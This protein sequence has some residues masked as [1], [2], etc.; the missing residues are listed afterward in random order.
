MSGDGDSL[1]QPGASP[2]ASSDGGRDAHIGSHASSCDGG[3]RG[4][5]GACSG[6]FRVGGATPERQS[7]QRA[8]HSCVPLRRARDPCR[9]DGRAAR[10]AGLR[11]R[12]HR[13]DRLGYRIDV[14][15]DGIVSASVRA[16]AGVAPSC[17]STASGGRPS[18]RST[19]ASRLRAGRRPRASRPFAARATSFSSG[20][21]QRRPTE[22]STCTWSCRCRPILRRTTGR[23]GR[24]GF[25]VCRRPLP[26]R[27]SGRAPRRQIRRG[28]GSRAAPSGIGSRQAAK[29]SSYSACRRRATSTRWLSCWSGRAPARAR[30]P[31]AEPT[32]EAL[33]ASRSGPVGA[34]STR[35]SSGTPRE[36]SAARSRS[37]SWRRMRRS[38][39]PGVCSLRVACGRA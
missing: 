13:R 9:G 15:P 35:S 39:S 6:A 5:G 2:D 27:P 38:G 34:P 19:A 26:A 31:A 33:R 20:G 36:P 28:A 18:A 4:R 22:S 25:G 17:V 37:G 10:S 23:R 21:G 7:R 11:V 8:G 32:P 12:Q 1:P 29:G 16:V 30:S 24:R 14:A 3:R